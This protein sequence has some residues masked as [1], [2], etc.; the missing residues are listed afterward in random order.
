MGWFD[1]QEA[2]NKVSSEKVE[3]KLKTFQVKLPD[4]ADFL[5]INKNGVVRVYEDEIGTPIIIIIDEAA[6]LLQKGSDKKENALKVE[7]EGIIQS[8]TQ[9]GRSSGIHII[10]TTQRND[11]SIINGIIQNNCLKFDTEV[12]TPD[13]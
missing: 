9:L 6:E 8:I 4:G 11:T 7:I 1:H 10:I 5:P 2:E 3:S 13:E 12:V